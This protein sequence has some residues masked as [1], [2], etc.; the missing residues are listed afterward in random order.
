MAVA[1]ASLII[2]ATLYA[3]LSNSKESSEDNILILSHG[4]SIILLL[5]YILYLFFQ[6]KTHAKFFDEVSGDEDE[7]KEPEVLTPI[8]AA[9][10]LIIITVLV[11]VCAEYLVNSIDAIVESAHISKTFVGLILL[12][13]VG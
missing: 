5:L 10:A 3:A 13:I 6:L 12:P 8:P 4:A 2:P 9:V 1:S 7:P 11:A